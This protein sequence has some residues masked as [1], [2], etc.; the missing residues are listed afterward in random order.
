MNTNEKL[1]ERLRL[2]F[3]DRAQVCRAVHPS[4]R[5]ARTRERVD[6]HQL[7]REEPAAVCGRREAARALR[8]FRRAHLRQSDGRRRRQIEG[9]GSD[10]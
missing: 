9:Y 3:S 10:T 4:A 8:P 1:N 6:V 5:A 2:N 7:F